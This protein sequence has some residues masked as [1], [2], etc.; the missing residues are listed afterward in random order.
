MGFNSI[1]FVVYFKVITKM[2]MLYSTLILFYPSNQ[3]EEKPLSFNLQTLTH[4]PGG[5]ITFS[6][7]PSINWQFASRPFNA[8]IPS[9]VPT[10]KNSCLSSQDGW[11]TKFYMDE[12]KNHMSFY[13]ENLKGHQKCITGSQVTAILLNGWICPSGQ[14]GEASRYIVLFFF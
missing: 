12:Q 13:I 1:S 5:R 14:S 7:Q 11:D 2:N 8:E 9:F 4:Q 6:F 10:N 3:E